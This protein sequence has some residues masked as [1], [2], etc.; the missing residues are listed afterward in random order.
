MTPQEYQFMKH[1]R[2]KITV[3]LHCL[4]SASSKIKQ[5]IFSFMK[6][7]HCSQ[8]R[9]VFGRWLHVSQPLHLSKLI[10]T[11]L[12]FREANFFKCSGLNNPIFKVTFTWISPNLA[13]IDSINEYID[14]KLWLKPQLAFSYQLQS[15]IISSFLQLS[16]LCRHCMNERPTCNRFCSIIIQALSECGL[17]FDFNPS[18]SEISK[19]S[20]LLKD[21]DGVSIPCKHWFQA[22]FCNSQS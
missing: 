6:V 4:S 21:A 12:T 18:S 19:K 7:R 15:C 22:N 3:F 5:H 11:V 17:N 16:V 13:C 2:H 14:S 10:V 20:Y 1:K 9:Y 8:A